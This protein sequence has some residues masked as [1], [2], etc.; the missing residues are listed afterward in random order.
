MTSRRHTG[1]VH[2]PACFDSA[3]R[4]RFRGPFVRGSILPETADRVTS[5]PPKV[6]M[7]QSRFAYFPA[8]SVLQQQQAANG[9]PERDSS[10]LDLMFTA[11]ALSVNQEKC[12][13]SIDYDS[14]AL[15]KRR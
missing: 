10:G 12:A 2:A 8:G 14:C 5:C 11:T 9:N 13:G 3:G 1:F 6:E 4:T 7:Q 15:L